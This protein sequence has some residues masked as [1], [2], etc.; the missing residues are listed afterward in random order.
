MPEFLCPSAGVNFTIRNVGPWDPQALEKPEALANYKV[1]AATHH[2][3]YLQATVRPNL[4]PLYPIDT[5]RVVNPGAS[6]NPNVESQ[7]Y[8]YSMHPDGACYPGSRL[9]ISQFTDGTT[10]T[11]MIVETIEDIYSRW[12]LGWE[13]SL[14]GLPSKGWDRVWYDNLYDGRFW[15]PFGFNGEYG[16]QT[17]VKAEFRTYL[18]HDYEDPD[19]EWS[20]YIP[21]PTTGDYFGQHY[22]PSSKHGDVVNHLM[23]DGA[24]RSINRN[25][26]VSA[27][28]FLITREGRDP[29]RTGGEED[30]A[31]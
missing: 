19:N 9:K 14:W 29:N 15:H 31:K 30:T 25:I 24:A 10:H 7:P 8:N 28:M 16:D 5:R 11:I 1:M 23:V 12:P 21:R 18:N 17:T 4:R 13:M 6:P 22:G 2:E 27:Y 3:S 26:D 20:W